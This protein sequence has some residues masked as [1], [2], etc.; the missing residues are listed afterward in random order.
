MMTNRNF[1]CLKKKIQPL[2]KFHFHFLNGSQY[3][4]DDYAY[5]YVDDVAEVDDDDDYDDDGVAGEDED[6]DL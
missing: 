1:H 4:V 5:D 2:D 6:D 3:I